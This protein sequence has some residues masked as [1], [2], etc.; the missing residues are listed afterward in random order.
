MFHVVLKSSLHGP[1]AF[2]YDTFLDAVEGFFRVKNKAVETFK[3]DGIERTVSLEF[4][5]S[6]LPVASA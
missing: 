5:T 3:T 2:E 6:E 1:E 4:Y